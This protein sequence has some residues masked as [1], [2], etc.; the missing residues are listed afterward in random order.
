VEKKD[1]EQK[2]DTPMP[3]SPAA[4]AEKNQRVVIMVKKSGEDEAVAVE[5]ERGRGMT[6]ANFKAA[7]AA[8]LKLQGAPADLTFQSPAH[9]EFNNNDAKLAEV[10]DGFDEE[11]NVLEVTSTHAA[12]H[13]NSEMKATIV[14]D[15]AND[16]N[17]SLAARKNFK[18]YEKQRDENLKTLQEALGFGVTLNC[19]Y[20]VLN[21]ASTD[22]GYENR[23]GEIVWGS[24]LEHLANAIKKFNQDDLCK[25]TLADA[26][27]AKK[28][29]TIR[30]NDS[31]SLPS[32]QN[33]RVRDGELVL[34]FKS[35]NWWTNVD[36]IDNDDGAAKAK[37]EADRAGF[38]S[39]SEEKQIE[40]KTREP[41]KGEE[42]VHHHLHETVQPVIEKE[43]IVPS[44]THK[45]V[46]VKE[47]IQEPSK[48][49]GVTT[50]STLS[51]EE[52]QDKLD[53]EKK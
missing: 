10:L 11:D 13:S 6:V 12:D 23:C 16:K 24:L 25:E 36:S 19:D 52:F 22:R 31:E 1:T 7:A 4:A 35:D 26:L 37:A 8:K 28:T 45:R 47:K 41:T 42:H 34:E 50:N 39:T 32:Y 29:V 51:V 9:P 18:E 27:K 14:G 38:E 44:V 15:P 46:D 33:L 53:G 40:S 43:V 21:K 48:H 17:L 30:V 5:I 20:V 49:H 2:M 3:T